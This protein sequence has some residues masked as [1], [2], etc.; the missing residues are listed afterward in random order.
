MIFSIF[1][2]GEILL[3]NVTIDQVW[4]AK[5]EDL[6]R[7]EQRRQ[8]EELSCSSQDSHLSPEP[9]SVKES[10]DRPVVGGGKTFEELLA[11]KLQEEEDGLKAGRDSEETPVRSRPFLKKGS[12]LARFNLNKET[13]AGKITT[14]SPKKTP[15]DSRKVSSALVS[16]STG[17]KTKNVSIQSPPKTLKL[18]PRYNLSDSVENSF[19]DKL[20]VAASRQEKDRAELEV[21]RM[22][23]TAANEASFCSNSSRIQNLVSAAV[24]PSPSRERPAQPSQS[25]LPLHSFVS[26]TPA[27]PTAMS[28]VMSS[29]PLAASP[30]PE[31]DRTEDVTDPSLGQSIMVDIKKF[32]LER[33]SDQREGQAEAEADK[34]SDWTDES[35][36]TDDT[37]HE[38]E[39]TT[40][41]SI[42]ENWRENLTPT[43]KTSGKSKEV[44]TFSP[45]EKLPANP[46]SQLIWNIFGRE[47]QK[48]KK[49]AQQ[50]RQ[51]T[52]SASSQEKTQSDT[53]R[54]KSAPL[55]VRFDPNTN[56]KDP[57]RSGRATGHEEETENEENVSYQS[58]LLRMRV[59]GKD[60]YI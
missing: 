26:S 54:R 7:D 30:D 53:Q 8:I 22:L 55:S 50:Q 51:R 57:S 58:T 9:D 60:L 33:L 25:S 32:L 40:E 37:L 24:L 1:K 21:F 48:K 59:A 14:P 31:L 6:L 45:P 49:E 20:S 10:E 15:R 23:E 44:L 42:G 16:S 27:P 4:Q 17:R 5:Q 2:T 3:F 38:N 36:D 52:K 41:P 19:C 18:T 28:S 34:E 29:M 12:G 35:D 11:E 47:N 46:P 43:S 39:E 56:R 13:P